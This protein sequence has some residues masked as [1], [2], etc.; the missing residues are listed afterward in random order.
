MLD[1]MPSGRRFFMTVAD[2]FS[3]KDISERQHLHLEVSG[4]I[5][6]LWKKLQYT[7]QF[8]MNDRPSSHQTHTQKV[9]P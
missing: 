9:V 7:F 6:V 3:E 8:Y 2:S 4:F 5:F 1:I